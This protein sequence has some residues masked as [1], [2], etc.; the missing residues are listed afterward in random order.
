[1]DQLKKLAESDRESPRRGR[2]DG[3]GGA[4]ERLKKMQ[5]R[6]EEE[7]KK[8]AAILKPDQFQRLKQI[9]WQVLGPRAFKNAQV[10]SALGLTAE[11]NE[12]IAKIMQ[13]HQT[14]LFSLMRTGLKRGNTEE[15][16][17]YNRQQTAKVHNAAVEKIVAL[18]TSE[19]QAKWK[20]LTGE[21]FTGEIDW[22]ELGGR[23]GRRTQG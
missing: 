5:E 23:G 17:A 20:E 16:K 18:L 9:S 15:D 4:K 22:M 3:E 12:G 19:Q 10:V 14:E 7:E 2:G 6:A 1:M 8:V 13:D 21:P 11:Q